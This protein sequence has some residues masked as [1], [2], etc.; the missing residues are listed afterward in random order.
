MLGLVLGAG[1]LLFS[2]VHLGARWGQRREG[3]NALFAP[4][5]GTDFY[6]QILIEIPLLGMTV[7]CAAVAGWTMLCVALKRWRLPWLY[8]LPAAFFAWVVFVVACFP[9]WEDISP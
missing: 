1:V 2:W 5:T 3:T 9:V 6:D 7:V 4:A 8:T